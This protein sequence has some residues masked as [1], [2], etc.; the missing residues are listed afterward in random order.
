PAR[1]HH[2]EDELLLARA[3]VGSRERDRLHF[4]LHACLAAD[5]AN[6][7]HWLQRSLRPWTVSRYACWISTVTGPGAPT[8]WAWTS[9][10]GSAA[11]AMTLAPTRGRLSSWP[12]MPIFSPSSPGSAPRGHDMITT[13]T[14]CPPDETPTSPYP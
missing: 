6:S 13:S 5:G 3:E 10:M 7:S 14:G 4:L 12:R 8:T 9:R 2:F 11:R 1:A